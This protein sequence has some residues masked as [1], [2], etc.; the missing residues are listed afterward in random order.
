MLWV[1]VF[2]IITKWQLIDGFINKLTNSTFFSFNGLEVPFNTDR[3]E[4]CGKSKFH[5]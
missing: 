5:R 1:A 4:L 2:F 3:E